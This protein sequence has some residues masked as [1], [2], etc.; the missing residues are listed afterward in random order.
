MGL[1]E[2]ERERLEFF[3]CIQINFWTEVYG[4]G[5]GLGYDFFQKMLFLKFFAHFCFFINLIFP[6]LISLKDEKV[7]DGII[8]PAKLDRFRMKLFTQQQVLQKVQKPTEY[9]R[10]P[11]SIKNQKNLLISLTSE[12]LHLSKP[13]WIKMVQQLDLFLVTI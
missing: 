8:R 9:R 7:S 11:K 12:N 6:K 13:L 4:L 10:A 1:R 3:L 2:K 5:V